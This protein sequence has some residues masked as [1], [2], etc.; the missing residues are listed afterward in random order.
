MIENVTRAGP[1]KIEIGMVRQI[2]NG[3]F[4]VV[5]AVLNLKLVTISPA[6][7]NRDPEI[8][9]IT[10]LFVFTEIGKGYPRNA[11]RQRAFAG[12]NDFIKALQTTMEMVPIVIRCQRISLAVERELSFRDAIA[13]AADNWTNVRSVLFISRHIVVAERYVTQVALTIRHFNRNDARSIGNDSDSGAALVRQRV[14]I[15]RLTI[16]GLAKR[17]FFNMGARCGSHRPRLGQAEG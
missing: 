14:N 15:N 3:C 10:F 17:L 9:R 5:R 6:V 8:A 16:G 11:G 2:E 4:V 1:R 13:V 7:A 12:P